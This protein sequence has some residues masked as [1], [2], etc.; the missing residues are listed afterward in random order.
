MKLGIRLLNSEATLNHYQYLKNIKINQGE[1]INLVFQLVNS[2][3]AGPCP[4]RF[5]PS[6]AACT[7]VEIARYPDWLGTFGNQR[8]GVDYSV[9]RNAAM[10]FPSDDR[11]IWYLPLT[12]QETSNMMSSNI[13]V[14]VTDGS[15]KY[16]A[17]LSAA[18][19]VTRSENDPN[20]VQPD[21]PDGGLL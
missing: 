14:T 9:R 4:V 17:V 6:A 8:I 16:I 12:S 2:S 19:V 13:R 7:M 15:S 21:V 10:L 11:S 20:P 5:L 1:T 18:L 3:Q